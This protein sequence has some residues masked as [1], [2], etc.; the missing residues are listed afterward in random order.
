MERELRG[1][2][3]DTVVDGGRPDTLILDFTAWLEDDRLVGWQVEL[4]TERSTT[5]VLLSSASATET[6]TFD[7]RFS[8]NLVA[9]GVL[10]CLSLSPYTVFIE[11]AQLSYGFEDA[12]TRTLLG[13][14][15]K[16][17]AGPVDS[18]PAAVD[19]AIIR[20]PVIEPP[21][22][23]LDLDP[24]RPARPARSARPTRAPVPTVEPAATRSGELFPYVYMSLWPAPAPAELALGFVRYPYPLD[25]A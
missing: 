23:V 12:P 18:D 3:T 17:D 11:A 25:A 9:H 22:L 10:R 16:L 20:P 21:P 13:R 5:P 4:R 1:T 6:V 14:L 15:V 2:W 7:Q 24:A 19:S 8:S